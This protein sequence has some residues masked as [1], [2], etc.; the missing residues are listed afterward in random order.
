MINLFHTNAVRCGLR[1][2][3][4]AATLCA[5]VA[6]ASNLPGYIS[7]AF[8]D[9]VTVNQ[10]KSNVKLG[11]NHSTIVHLP[12]EV[13]DVVVANS[14]VASAVV[15][16]ANNLYLFGKNVGQTN[17]VAI[18]SEGKTI[19]DISITVERDLSSLRQAMQQYLPN[20]SI[21]VT[22]MND[23]VVLSGTVEKASD[24]EKAE[25]LAGA[26]ISGGE[27]SINPGALGEDAVSPAYIKD[28]DR[29]RSK[30]INLLQILGGQQVTLKVTVAE[31]S[32]NVTKQLGID[33]LSN[34]NSGF[35]FDTLP[36]LI[37]KVQPQ[38]QLGTTL[39][40]YLNAMESAGAMKIVAEPTLTAISGETARFDVGGE[41]NVINSLAEN[42]RSSSS[43]SLI[44]YGIG[45]EFLPV[46]LSPGRISLKVVTDVSE[47]NPHAR[48]GVAGTQMIELNRRRA[49]STIE[50]P[51]GGSMMI[52]GLVSS[53]AGHE[54]SAVPE[55]S[56]LPLLGAMFRDDKRTRSDK[57]LVIIVTPYLARPVN[58][59][60]LSRPSDNLDLAS[61]SSALFLGI[62]NKKYG[63]SSEA[64]KKG[65][66]HGV[67]GY[68]NK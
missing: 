18:D 48:K 61:D 24:V 39:M 67:V 51:S 10:Q 20:C 17:L 47:P 45:L 44:K 42:G 66:Y 7:T 16:S 2:S 50:L 68:I 6:T 13:S 43:L 11:L 64:S 41:Y 27:A 22:L 1:L 4:K 19:S 9:E 32:R 55:V 34:N 37:D 60:D 35:Q 14:S 28:E 33:L 49:S 57:E 40:A 53:Q 58:E 59:A 29:R 38:L 21:K 46:V 23:N 62:V 56:K 65:K 12:K 3:F 25:S 52:A 63:G 54:R 8:A 36:G 26:F 31:V 5:V 30:I 15:R